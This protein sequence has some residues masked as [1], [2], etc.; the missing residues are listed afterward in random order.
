[1]DAAFSA[2][3]ET[4]ADKATALM[5]VSGILEETCLLRIGEIEREEDLNEVKKLFGD[6]A[7]SLEISLDFQDFDQELFRLPGDYSPPDGSIL[8]ASWEEEVAGCVALR[9]FA[10]GIC[11]MKRLYTKPQ[12][13]GLGIGRALSEAII[14]RARRIGYER[15]RLDT[16]PS[17][18]TARGLYA[19]LGFKEIEPYRYNPIEGAHFMEL[20]L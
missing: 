18:E 13:R 19:S 7:S 15:M 5:L 6:Y 17:M 12:F 8:V 2:L 1:M 20:M 16:L 9:K 4:S 14:A 10:N 3:A 11:E